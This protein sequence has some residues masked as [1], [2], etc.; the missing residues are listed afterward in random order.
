MEIVCGVAG[1][2]SGLAWMTDSAVNQRNDRL[3][4]YRR[5]AELHAANLDQGF[6]ASLGHRFLA[7][8]YQAIDEAPDSVLIVARTDA[9]GIV[10]FV[11]GGGGMGTV[12]RRML[13]YWWRL[14]VSLVPV[15]MS[16]RKLRRIMEI[17][18]YGSAHPEAVS[19]EPSHIPKAELLSIAVDTAYRGKGHA[20][21][22]YRDLQ[23]HFRNRGEPGFRIVVG[24][25]LVTA[26]RFYQRMGARAV[27][28]IEV[29]RGERSVLYVHALN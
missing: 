23:R 20:E 18:R 9:D 4:M 28:Q 27:A 5:V 1:S 7:L 22:L 21:Q 25:A 26:H 14:G 3:A 13:R 2:A 16:P 10:G 11:A 6:L 12:C 24:A 17:F 29:H 15:L 8:M 19:A